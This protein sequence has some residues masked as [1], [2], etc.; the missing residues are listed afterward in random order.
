MDLK[1]LVTHFAY[2]IES[3]PEGG[4]VARATDPSVSPIEASTREELQ[5]RIR[6]NILKALSTEFPGLKLPAEGKHLEM[7]FHVEHTPGGG[8]T[9]HSA[10]PNTAAI[11]TIDPNDFESKFLEKFLGFA[12]KHLMPE[13]SKALAA[14]VGSANIKVV[15]NGKTTLR[16]NS[17][18]Q[19]MAFGGPKNT[20][21]QIPELTDS[22]DLGNFS[23]TIGN[24]PITPESSNMGKVFGFLLLV[25]LVGSLMYVFFH[26][27]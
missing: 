3:K 17:N 19:G 7:S 2:R 9:I 1:Q 21:A 14:Q 12:G 24:T 11:E 8:F 5:Q 26:F 25:L 13:L 18:S 22:T 23:G 20:A 10:D 27:R 6:E 16:V 4:F 15:V